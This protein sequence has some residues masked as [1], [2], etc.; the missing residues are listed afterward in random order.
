MYGGRKLYQISTKLLRQESIDSSLG[1][2]GAVVV[3]PIIKREGQLENKGDLR[4]WMTNDS[5]R[6]PVR[7]YAKFRKIRDWTLQAEL[8]PPKEGG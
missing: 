6:I 7:I 3:Q 5:R 8:L 2:V 1:R 4:M